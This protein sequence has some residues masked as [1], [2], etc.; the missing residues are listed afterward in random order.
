LPRAAK[1][2]LIDKAYLDAFSIL[3][4]DNS[5]SR[6]YGG[7]AAIEVLNRLTTQLA[8]THLENSIAVR[9][10]GITTLAQ[11]N[12]T[13][14]S[15]RLFQRAELN[16]NGPFYK[17]IAS[18][19]E[20]VPGIGVFAPNTRAARVTILLHELGHLIRKP[21]KEWLLPNDGDSDA[22]SR[23][24]TNQVIAMCTNQITQLER[25][26]FEEE[27]LSAYRERP[28]PR[29]ASEASDQ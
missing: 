19:G 14:I 5:C 26:S 4:D 22:R 2:S 17:S 6:F 21:N 16:L 15:Y 28:H 24:N 7:P 8:T 20:V 10:T 3:N 25:L 29:A 23:E 1:L 27:L 18:R 11:N 9:M 12:S 13:G